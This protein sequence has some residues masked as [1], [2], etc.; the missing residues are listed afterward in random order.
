M[1]VIRRYQILKSFD[2]RATIRFSF[3]NV[4]LPDK[5]PQQCHKRVIVWISK[6]FSSLD[7]VHTAIAGCLKPGNK[8]SALYRNWLCV[9]LK[10]G[11]FR[12]TP[13]Q[14]L[15]AIPLYWC[16]TYRLLLAS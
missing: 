5:K 2:Y 3:L 4:A 14:L 15:L 11:D 10:S 12:T 1:I 8:K 6:H 13:T 9:V 16:R 7:V